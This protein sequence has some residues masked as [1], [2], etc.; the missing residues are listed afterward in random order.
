[1]E[2]DHPNFSFLLE[3][4]KKSLIKRKEKFLIIPE[5][6][7]GAT[8]EENLWLACSSCNEFKGTQTHARDAVTGR[9]VRLFNPR[10]QRWRVHFT[11]SE[12]GAEI[13]GLTPCGRAT[14]IALK[15]NH[16]DIVRARKRWVSVGWWPPED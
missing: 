3:K 2:I 15:M 10:K 6:A 9:R 16:E 11:W 4:E 1:M 7:F 5:S 13:I 14:V 8:T 12:D